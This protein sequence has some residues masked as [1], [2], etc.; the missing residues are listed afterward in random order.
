MPF[1][2][3]VCIDG[4]KHDPNPQHIT[5]TE[6]NVR[7]RRELFVIQANKSKGI[8]PNYSGAI[9]SDRKLLLF[10]IIWGITELLHVRQN[11]T[12][13]LSTSELWMCG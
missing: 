4:P 2:S 7:L 13:R 1:D 9:R 3:R 10:G 8:L 6:L 11:Q 5:P 12:I